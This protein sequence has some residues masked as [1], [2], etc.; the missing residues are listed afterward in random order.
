M[1][2]LDLKVPPVALVG[3]IA[4]GMW[5]TS[6]IFSDLSFA[7]PGA[8]WWSSGIAA[9][10]FWIAILGVLRFRAAGTTVDPRVPDQS[11]SL[12]VSGIY[13][14]SRNPMYLGF[15]LVLCAWGLFLGNAL[16]LAGLPMFVLYMNRF[17]IDPEERFMQE[18]FGDQYTR[19][20]AGVRRW[21]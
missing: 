15:L 16:A 11:A 2:A 9:A 4:A 21:I 14:Y 17:Q 19:Y 6:E 10:G 20:R 8:T 18:K 7:V 13:R 5:V 3:I 12:V 1:S